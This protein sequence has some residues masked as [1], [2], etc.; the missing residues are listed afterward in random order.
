MRCMAYVYVSDVDGNM[1]CFCA[2]L[3]V[4]C[5]CNALLPLPATPTVHHVTYA[6]ITP[7]SPWRT[8]NTGEEEAC[9][10]D[11]TTVKWSYIV[12]D[13]RCSSS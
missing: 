8:V 1:M 7:E 5:R 12:T 13:A 4:L 2:F 3:F 6:V 11:K 10:A 9:P